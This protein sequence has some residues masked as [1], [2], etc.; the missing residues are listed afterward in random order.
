MY[1]RMNNQCCNGSTKLCIVVVALTSAVAWGCAYRAK[2]SGTPPPDSQ[3]GWVRFVGEFVLYDDESA[4][5]GSRMD[6]CMSG[7]LP[8]E[9][10]LAAAKK[11]NGRRVRVTGVRIAW[12]LPDPQALS[13]NH[14]GSPIIN[15]CGGDFVLFA[16]DMVP[17]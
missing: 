16:T 11:M 13:L 4:F 15:R 7:A 10:Q 17:E 8:L 6:H 9:K 12:S 14:D 2:A 1:V 5:K 3:V